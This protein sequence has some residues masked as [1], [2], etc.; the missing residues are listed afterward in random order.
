MVS[1]LKACYF[2]PLLCTCVVTTEGFSSLHA[3]RTIRSIRGSPKASSSRTVPHRSASFPLSISYEELQERLPS[4]KVVEAVER[5]SSKVVAAD[6]AT[7]AGVSLA[8]AR[9]DLQ[10]LASVSRGDIAV[11]KDGELIYSFPNN[12]SGVLAENSRKYQ[13]QQLARKVWPAIFW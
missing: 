7:A 3:G 8:Q 5:S 1:S 6:V 13:V 12:L 2:V 11:D 10:A 9:Q 4:Q